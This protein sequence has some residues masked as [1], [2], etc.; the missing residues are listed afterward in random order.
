MSDRYNISAIQGSTLLLNLNIKD[1]NG[2]YINLSGYTARGYVRGKYSNTGILLD[3]QPQIHPSYVSGLVTLSGAQTGMAAMP[4]G[5]FPYEV[6]ISGSNDYVYKAIRGY[7][8]CDPE[9]TY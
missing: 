5:Q 7:F 2:S 9:A 6:E 4:V 1:S 8:S 3:L